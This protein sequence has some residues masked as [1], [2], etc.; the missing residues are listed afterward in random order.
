MSNRAYFAGRW[1]AQEAR[2]EGQAYQ[3]MASSAKE[4]WTAGTPADAGGVNPAVDRQAG[5][6]PAGSRLA[7]AKQRLGGTAP[8]ER[9]RL[10]SLDRARRFAGEPA[11]PFARLCWKYGLPIPAPEFQFHP[12]RRWRF[13]YAWP[14]HKL[15]LEV[16]GGIWRKGGGAHSHPLNIE[17]DCEK[18]SEAALLGWRILRAA[19]EMLYSDGWRLVWRAFRHYEPE[20]RDGS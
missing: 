4:R 13:D 10:A 20:E 11:D 5:V 2:R 16:E 14:D 1:A 8:Q 15:A 7:D 18:Y 9:E 6:N 19:P 12:S 3:D 17:R